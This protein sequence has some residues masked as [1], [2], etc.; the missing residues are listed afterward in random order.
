MHELSNYFERFRSEMAAQKQRL[1]DQKD[2]IEFL[3]EA[4]EV[5]EWINTQMAVAASEDYGKDVSHVEMLIKTFDSF[6]QTIHSSEERI[7][8]VQ[9]I[10]QR[11]LRE[12]NSHKETILRKTSDI[13]QLWEDLKEPASAR[14]EALSGA[15]QV[16]VF[17]K[18]ADETI[19][20]ISEKEAEISADEVGQD[21]ETIQS[22]IERQEGF[23]RDLAAIQQQVSAVEKEA[24][25]LCELFPDA[26]AHIE[27]KRE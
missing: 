1:L 2:V 27:A 26:A 16:H 24:S 4:E 6:L 11:L 13:S 23:Q 8:R 17:D 9:E 7:S 15:K 18:N 22:L 19:S 21:L 10:S 20:W 25:V 3:H 12:D 14:H 5:N